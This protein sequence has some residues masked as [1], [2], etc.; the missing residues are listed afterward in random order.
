MHYFNQLVLFTLLFIQILNEN[1]DIITNDDVLNIL[2]GRNF[3]KNL[4]NLNLILKPI[5]EGI[6]ILESDKTN[7]A[8]CYY[9]LIKLAASIKT[10][11]SH[12]H[13]SYRNYCI[14]KFN[15]RWLEFNSDE[16]LVAYF[17]HPGYK[18]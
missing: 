13:C 7:L 8:D 18:G 2:N 4:K 6:E 14:R 5:K 11:P 9:Q 12:F 17:L 3:F 15:S 10:I 16:Y 1:P